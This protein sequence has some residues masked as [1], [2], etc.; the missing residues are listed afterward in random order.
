MYCVLYSIFSRV[1]TC[2]FFQAT[3]TKPNFEPSL[4]LNCF[5]FTAQP[6][7]RHQKLLKNWLHGVSF[8]T[9]SYQ[10]KFVRKRNAC[11]HLHTHITH[12]CIKGVGTRS[13]SMCVVCGQK[14]GLLGRSGRDRVRAVRTCSISAAHRFRLAVHQLVH[15]IS[16]HAYAMWWCPPPT[17]TTSDRIYL[18]LSFA[19]SLSPSEVASIQWVRMECVAAYCMQ[20]LS[21]ITRA[22]PSLRAPANFF[23]R[24]YRHTMCACMRD[25]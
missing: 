5:S 25:T 1:V 4:H 10:H 19:L 12:T 3:I 11:A 20:C 14:T 13:H 9:T 6:S 15:G 16:T 8:S 17:P 23:K 22:C 7:T 21:Q 2:K 18:C 24:S